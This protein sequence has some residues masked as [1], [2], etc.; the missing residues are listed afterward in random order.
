MTREILK[1]LL[2]IMQAFVYG[3]KIEYSND[4]E[5]WLETETPTWDTDFVYRVKPEPK[6]DPKTLKPFDK[7]LTK[8]IWD[9]YVWR[10]DLFSHYKE[11]NGIIEIHCTNEDYT[12]TKC[13]PYN[14]E[15]KR[16]IG[17]TDEAPEY[18]RY[19]E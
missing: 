4:G 9:G 12:Y 18:Y 7:V 2:P 13:V 11:R 15:T 19:W 5:N 8:N 6:F 14:E 10:C 1:D 3:K 17:T 16:L